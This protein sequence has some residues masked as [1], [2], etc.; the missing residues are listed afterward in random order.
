MGARNEKERVMQK[1]CDVLHLGVDVYQEKRLSYNADGVEFT[2]DG[3]TW[4][5]WVDVVLAFSNYENVKM[6]T[7]FSEK[8]DL[9]A[10]RI[11]YE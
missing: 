6:E 2:S 5:S 9:V 4:Y 3:V 1:S 8:Y 7:Y 11:V 10:T